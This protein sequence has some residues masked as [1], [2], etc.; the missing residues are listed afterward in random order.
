VPGPVP[1]PAATLAGMVNRRLVLLAAVPLLLVAGC[2]A[3]NEVMGRP[4]SASTAARTTTTTASAV[5]PFSGSSGFAILLTFKQGHGVTY[6]M[7]DAC[8]EG[9]RYND[10][11]C[12]AQLQGLDDVAVDVV[13][14]LTGHDEA[15]SRT[16]SAAAKDVTDGFSTVSDMG[17]FGLPGDGKKMPASDLKDLCPTSRM[18]VMLPYLDLESTVDRP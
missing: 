18:V 12:G 16:I 17:C 13:D 3:H 9:V 4:V 2:S 6:P 7:G 15:Q 1:A 5:P 14:V 11:A 10:K 8:P